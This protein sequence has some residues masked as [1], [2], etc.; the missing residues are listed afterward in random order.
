MWASLSVCVYFMIMIMIILFI[1]KPNDE[2][3]NKDTVEYV[4]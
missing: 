1:Y 3:I 4:K 2:V